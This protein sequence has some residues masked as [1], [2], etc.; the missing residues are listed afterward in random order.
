M[1]ALAF[2]DGRLHVG[3]LNFS[4]YTERV[5]VA[6]DCN[7]VEWRPISSPWIQRRQGGKT[8]G[9]SAGGAWDAG[10][11]LPDSAFSLHGSVDTPTTICTQSAVG[12][13]AYF[14]P[15]VPATYNVDGPA[16]ELLRFQIT[17]PISSGR[18]VRGHVLHTADAATEATGNDTGVQIGAVG[19]TQRLYAALHVFSLSGTTPTVDVKI[20]S[21]DNSGFTSA[22]DRITFTQVSGSGSTGSQITSVA[23]AITDDYFRVVATLGGT[24]PS[25]TFCVVCGIA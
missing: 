11:G 8:V 24:S 5:E 16:A 6:I 25:T 9:F 21:D 13:I 15:S 7:V 12:S 20:Q 17:A 23:G 10:T 19:A 1:G 14:F 22:T 4:D 3:A 18:A 2:V